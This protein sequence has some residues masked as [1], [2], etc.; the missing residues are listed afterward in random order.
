MPILAGRRARFSSS[1][2][3]SGMS[4]KSICLSG[5]CAPFLAAGL[6]RAD[7][8]DDFL[9][10]FRSP[11]GVNNQQLRAYDRLTEP[12]KSLFLA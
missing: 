5:I 4:E 3:N 11:N 9:V 2:V 12:Q 6:A 7:N 8:P 10:I 1:S